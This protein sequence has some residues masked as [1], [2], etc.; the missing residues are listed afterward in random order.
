MENFKRKS[1]VQRGDIYFIDLPKDENVQGG[2]RP[3]IVV[4]N[5]KGCE[6]SPNVIVLPL[7]SRLKKNYM[8]THI[9]INAGDA[10]LYKD[11]VVLGENPITVSKSKLGDYVGRAD[12]FLM[13]KVDRIIAITF[14][15]M[16][17]NCGI[18]LDKA[19]PA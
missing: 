10:G 17:L 8:P 7:T 6:V 5:E 3:C 9:L 14:G 2:Y 12:N 15:L 18:E 13:S 16:P 1:S 4:G 11:S 19:C